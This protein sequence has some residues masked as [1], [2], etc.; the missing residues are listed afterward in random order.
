MTQPQRIARTTRLLVPLSFGG[1]LVVTTLWAALSNPVGGDF[2]AYALPSANFIRGGVLSLPQLGTQYDLDKYWRFNAPLLGAG[3][4]IPFALF[5]VSHT[6][7]LGGLLALAATSLTGLLALC[8]KAIG[9]ASAVWLPAAIGVLLIRSV[10]SVEL[11]NQR[12]SILAPLAVGL[13]FFPT[14]RERDG[15]RAAGWKWLLAGVLPLLHP[16]LLP[17]SFVW[18]LFE[19]A[20]CLKSWSLPHWGSVALGVGVGC[21]AWWYLSPPG[22]RVQ[23][24]PHLYSREFVPFSGWDQAA[25]WKYALPSQLTQGLIIAW[26]VVALPTSWRDSQRVRVLAC[27]AIALLLDASGRMVYLGYYVVGLAPAILAMH[28]DRGGSRWVAVCLGCLAVANVA[29]FAKLSTTPPRL[30]TSEAT[31]EGFVMTHT[32]DGD[33]IC[34]GP[35]FI[36]LASKRRLAGE[37]ELPYVVPTALYLRH[38]DEQQF[39]HAIR[40]HCTCYVGDPAIYRAVQRYYKMESAPVFET[41]DFVETVFE[42]QPILIARAKQ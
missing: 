2:V 42:G 34:L 21:C 17:A 23:F 35:P 14:R 1:A 37:R 20:A 27:L 25:S 18:V 36:L 31:I 12:Y 38:F 3:P 5:G 9:G 22:F 26:A 32:R 10:H 39:L 4:S 16:A 28:R 29:V 40:T 11:V 8:R 15:G 13:L 19:F 6:T 30:P 7:Y 33:R 24:L 41:A